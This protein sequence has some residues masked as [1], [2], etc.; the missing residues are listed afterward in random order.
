MWGNNLQRISRLRSYVECSPQLS[1]KLNV[2]PYLRERV[3]LFLLLLP[4]LLL[5]LLLLLLPLCWVNKTQNKWIQ[6]WNKLSSGQS[7]RCG[8]SAAGEEEGADEAV[9]G[10][11]CEIARELCCCCCYCCLCCCYC[12]IFSM[13]IFACCR[14]TTRTQQRKNKE[15]KNPKTERLG[16]VINGNA[17]QLQLNEEARTRRRSSSSSSCTRRQLQPVRTACLYWT[18]HWHYSC[19]TLASSKWE[20]RKQQAESGK[21]EK[22]KTVKVKCR[23]P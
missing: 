23:I 6:M 12:L 3:S 4:L 15:P 22:R 8:P 7:K 18:H 1:A 9:W 14:S 13:L 17:V 2:R 5:L 10:E 21:A 19:V 20:D 16:Q 11:S